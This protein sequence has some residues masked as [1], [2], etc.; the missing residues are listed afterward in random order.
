MQ[1]KVFQLG[2]HLTDGIG[3]IMMKHLVGHFGTAE[4]VFQATVPQLT[5][6][7]GVGEKLAF[8][9]RNK[10]GLRKAESELK[11]VQTEGFE[12]IFFTDKHY[13]QRLK[14]L[15]DSPALFY[16]RGNHDLN[17]GQFV[18]IVGTR[19]VTDYGKRVTEELVQ[20][21]AG[22]SVTIVSGLAYG[23][24]I[25]AHRAALKYGLPTL[26]V[27]ATGLDILYPS[28]HLKTS[29]EMQ[30]QGGLITENALGTKPDAPR[31]V[32]RNRIIAGLSDVVVV[33]ESAARGGSLV[34][35]EYAN[36]YNRD[37]YAVPG[38]VGSAFSVGCNHL[39]RDHKAEIYTGVEDFLKSMRW[40]QEAAVPKLVKQ[41]TLP[42]HFTQEES[43]IVALLRQH[44]EL[45]VDQLAWHSQIHPGKLASLLLN[46]ELQGYLK[47]LPGKRL[48]LA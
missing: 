30:A 25:I 31:F 29:Q 5:R 48:S 16:W 28:A 24:D 18:G 12:I 6:V 15:Y 36:N 34:T 39:I 41:L 38:G 27:M 11:R 45:Q 7:H 19:K 1:D 43:Q 13:P 22:Q 8:A 26:A 35:A 2:L 32:A 23:V 21:L 37:V 9:L 47:T 4:K 3:S 10:E 20:G 40:N 14:S 33:V 44:G 17:A 46:L 42:D